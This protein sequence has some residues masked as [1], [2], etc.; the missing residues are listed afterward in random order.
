MV[1]SEDAEARGQIESRARLFAGDDGTILERHQNWTSAKYVG[2]RSCRLF[3]S[4]RRRHTRLQGDW[5][6]DVC[7]SDLKRLEPKCPADAD[8][9]SRAPA[10][11][12]S[13]QQLRLAPA[14]AG[15]RP[16]TANAQGPLPV[17]LPD[18]GI[19]FP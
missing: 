5:S 8:R 2:Y 19:R 13:C 9:N 1:N 6:S 7:S 17:R 15:F 10:T 11:R 16:G 12:Q 14:S 18:V 4:S 3:F